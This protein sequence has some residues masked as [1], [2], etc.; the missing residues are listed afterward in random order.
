MGS[1][2]CNKRRGTS[3]K[4]RDKELVKLRKTADG[5]N[6][7][8]DEDFSANDDNDYDVQ[9]EQGEQGGQGGQGGLSIAH[10]GG[11]ANAHG[12]RSVN[13]HGSGKNTQKTGLSCSNCG[14]SRLA[15]EH[16][17]PGPAGPD[18]LCVMC[19]ASFARDSTL[20]TVKYDNK[21]VV[22]Q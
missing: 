4:P 15:P 19:G 5:S 12:G 9:S 14:C 2:A 10:K 21:R 11:S 17:R 16:M 13:A 3:G 8:E 18:S 1:Y 6:E 7:D 20:P 22:T